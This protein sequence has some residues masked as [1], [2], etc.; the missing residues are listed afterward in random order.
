MIATEGW[1]ICLFSFYSTMAGQISEVFNQLAGCD[2]SDKLSAVAIVKISFDALC[3]TL[4]ESYLTCAS[5]CNLAVCQQGDL[6]S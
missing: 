1:N 5:T 4:D 2:E 3:G 6:C